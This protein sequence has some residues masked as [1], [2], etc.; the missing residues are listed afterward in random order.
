[1]EGKEPGFDLRP[2]RLQR[3]HDGSSLEPAHLL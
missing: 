3:F 2:F 1:V